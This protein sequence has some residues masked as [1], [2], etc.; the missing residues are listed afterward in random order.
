MKLFWQRL[1]DADFTKVLSDGNVFVLSR[2]LLGPG[3]RN[4]LVLAFL[5]CN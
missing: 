2:V 1:G 3:L 5:N 4:A